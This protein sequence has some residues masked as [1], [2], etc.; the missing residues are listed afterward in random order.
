VSRE[1]RQHGR[2]VACRRPFPIAARDQGDRRSSGA[3]PHSVP[4]DRI[5]GFCG[6][7]DC[8]RCECQRRPYPSNLSGAL[9]GVCRASRVATAGASAADCAGHDGADADSGDGAGGCNQPGRCLRSRDGCTAT[10]DLSRIHQRRPD[11]R[12]VRG[13][14]ADRPRD[15]FGR[16]SRGDAAEAEPHATEFCRVVGGLL[17]RGDL[18][19]SRGDEVGSTTR[20]RSWR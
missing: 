4:R 11:E 8:V 7:L 6:A 13:D 2:L 18:R 1:L 20:E 17:V 10:T 12:P 5:G 3:V 14:C 9:I 16:F 19:T 15:Y